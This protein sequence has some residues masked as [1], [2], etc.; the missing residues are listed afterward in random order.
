MT[1][2]L[3]NK[4]TLSTACLEVLPKE[5]VFSV[6]KNVAAWFSCVILHWIKP[7]DFQNNS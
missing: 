7:Q 2:E 1:V 4:G 3:E 5:I 6:K